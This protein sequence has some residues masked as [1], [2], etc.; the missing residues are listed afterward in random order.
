M[1]GCGTRRIGTRGAHRAVGWQ[2]CWL[3]VVGVVAT[4]RFC[5]GLQ[6]IMVRAWCKKRGNM[7]RGPSGPATH[8]ERGWGWTQWPADLLERVAIA[9]T[10]MAS[11]RVTEG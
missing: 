1:Q 11:T 8:Q 10:A 7:R 2:R 9:S 6:R 3:L 4:A 5:G